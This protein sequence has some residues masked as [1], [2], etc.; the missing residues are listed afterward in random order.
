MLNIRE[1]ARSPWGRVDHVVR[2]SDDIVFVSTPGHGGY[3]LSREANAKVHVVWRRAGGW[4]EEDVDWAIVC[5]TFAVYFT[6]ND[7]AQATRVLK[8][9]LPSEFETVTGQKV[10]L[11]ESYMR[12]LQAFNRLAKS[13]WVSGAAWGSH[14][15]LPQDMVG[16]CFRHEV[17]GEA[18]RMMPTSMFDQRPEFGFVYD[19]L[20]P[21]TL[22]WANPYAK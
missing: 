11:E 10:T 8:S 18:Y 20:E 14:A 12:R 16:V 21:H 13:R 2:K 6:A 4:Y 19:D 22:P 1:G 9:Y 17:H 5:W 3:K 7:L 15:T